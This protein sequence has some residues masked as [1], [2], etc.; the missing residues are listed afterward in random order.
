MPLCSGTTQDEN[1]FSGEIGCP[2]RWRLLAG[3]NAYKISMA[4]INMQKKVL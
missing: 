1:L 2:P 3:L 4:K